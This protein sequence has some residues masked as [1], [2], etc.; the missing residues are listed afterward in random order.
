MS[1]K[2]QE[3]EED[4]KE[5]TD[6]K[7]KGERSRSA[8]KAGNAGKKGISGI[9]TAFLIILMLAVSAGIII[10]VLMK[11]NE[12]PRSLSEMKVT[13]L[14]CGTEL[15][16]FDIRFKEA[17]VGGS[18]LVVRLTADNNT[19]KTVVYEESFRVYCEGS[20]VKLKDSSLFARPATGITADCAS[21]LEYEFAGYEDYKT[22]RYRIEKNIVVENEEGTKEES[23]RL[24]LELVIE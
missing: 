17:D 7:E 3:L 11:M 10:Y 1:R 18:N 2:N 16:G 4:K 24:W 9:I 6:N 23:S 20:E 13:C 21:E 12:K 15:E 14:S 8:E 22:G 19:G 5:K